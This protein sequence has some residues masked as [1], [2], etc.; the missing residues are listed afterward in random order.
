MGDLE[1]GP[2]GFSRHDDLNE[3][4]RFVEEHREVWPVAWQCDVLGLTRSKYYRWRATK[5][6]R[7]AAKEADVALFELIV[8]VWKSSRSGLWVQADHP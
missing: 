2:A 5:D 1:E 4:Y 7:R 3:R 8:A 6:A